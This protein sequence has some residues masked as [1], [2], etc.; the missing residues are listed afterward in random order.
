L[1]VT[2]HVNFYIYLVYYMPVPIDRRCMHVVHHALI[3]LK[4]CTDQHI[5]FWLG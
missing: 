1:F 2:V 5:I 4:V 3:T